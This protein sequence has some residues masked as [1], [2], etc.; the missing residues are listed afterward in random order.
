MMEDGAIVVS[1][2]PTD[3]ASIEETEAL[4]ANLGYRRFRRMVQK[5]RCP[6]PSSYIGSGFCL[7][8]AGAAAEGGFRLVVVDGQLTPTQRRTLADLLKLEV[9]DRPYLIMKIFES[10]AHTAE[11]K[12]QVQL[13]AMKH[14]IPY[15]KGLG[16]QMSRAGGGIGTRGPGETEF[17]R[18]R[19]KIVRRARAVEAKLDE[20][21]RRRSAQRERRER[22]GIKTVALVGYTNSGKTTLLSKLSGDVDVK[23][24][25]K[26]FA[27]LDTLT[28]GVRLDDHRVVIFSDTVGFI[29]KLP[30]E[31]VAAFRA[32]L[33]EV[34]LADMV[35]MV[36]DGASPE[37]INHLDVIEEVLDQIGAGNV[38]RLVL[39]NKRDIWDSDG[40][41]FEILS[42][43]KARG[44][45]VFPV[46][47]LTG[48]GI[49]EFLAWLSDVI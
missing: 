43:V 7:K 28:R 46:S 1:I 45:P 20:L 11:A 36:I 24:A 34:A 13:A 6:D 47:A 35:A 39:L 49:Q 9:W 22:L 14:E 19:R 10:R 40:E 25:D 42:A 8:V 16:F 33:E 5:R 21:R 26:L 23:G 15:L 27:T 4:L 2:D 32:T 38:R 17:E 31:L 44:F 3:E 37:A 41:G 12:L 18:H 30:V 29:R 48:Q